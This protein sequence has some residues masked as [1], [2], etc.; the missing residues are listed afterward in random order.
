MAIEC[1]FILFEKWQQEG[2]QREK[3]RKNEKGRRMETVFVINL[4]QSVNKEMRSR[5]IQ[6]PAE[7]NN[8]RISF[9]NVM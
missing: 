2:K 7:K 5:I 1:E 9:K 6:S 3:S 4:F 8:K